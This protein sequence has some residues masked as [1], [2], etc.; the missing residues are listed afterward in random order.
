MQE[1]IFSTY[2]WGSCTS[3]AAASHVAEVMLTFARVSI[4]TAFLQMLRDY[5]VGLW[6]KQ[7]L[8]CAF[9]FS[10]LQ[11][12]WFNG[13][14]TRRWLR[15]C[16]LRNQK[17]LTMWPV[18]HHLLDKSVRW[19][20]QKLKNLQDQGVVLMPQ[21]LLNTE[22]LGRVGLDSVDSKVLHQARQHESNK[23]GL[24]I[25]RAERRSQVG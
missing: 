25:H 19:A 14:C 16:Y 18:G 24:A 9:L 7:H 13:L 15:S 8:R 11:E 10:R 23:S 22:P 5:K 2:R 17:G 12:P 4:F 21:W 6:A 20:H 3:Y 1:G